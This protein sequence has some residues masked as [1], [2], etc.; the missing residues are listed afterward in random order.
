MAKNNQKRG[1]IIVFIIIIVGWFSY[2]IIKR[3]FVDN[4][5]LI[6]TSNDKQFSVITYNT[7]AGEFAPKLRLFGQI[8]AKDDVDLMAF[9]GGTITKIIKQKGSYVKAGDII[10]EHNITD[11][12]AKVAE[13]KALVK[14]RSIEYSSAKELE[15]NSFKA[16]NSVY[17]ALSLLEAAKAKLAKA[18]QD[19]LDNTV[20]APITGVIND[21]IVSRGDTI[22]P[23]QK[24]GSIVDV[25]HLRITFHIP[26]LD[27]DDIK[28]GNNC[29]ITRKKQK[30]NGQ[31]THINS[32]AD[33]TT[34]TFAAE[35]RVE[36][37]KS[38]KLLPG[39]TMAVEVDK[40]KVLS[41]K[42]PISSIVLNDQGKIVIRHLDN[43]NKVMET[44]I[45]LQSQN[46][47][48]AYASGLPSEIHLIISGQEF[49]KVGQKVKAKIINKKQYD[50]LYNGAIA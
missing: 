11:L 43:N 28:I 15:K 25:E 20:S 34:R 42:I 13:A 26:E 5:Q 48:F 49:V 44:P 18:Q 8:I 45:V 1:V 39:F 27:V 12:M 19:L 6:S 38:N 35:A 36:L 50:N 17:G 29:V 16:K 2:N 4:S 46:G 24:I 32:R 40:K 23:N 41:H 22:K 9:G 33:L 21:L 10:L 31:I 30:W 14:Q 47:A 37:N 7:K 3:N